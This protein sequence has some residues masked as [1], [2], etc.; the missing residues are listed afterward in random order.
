MNKPVRSIEARKEFS[1]QLLRWWLEN[2]RDFLWR[3]SN[4]AYEVLIAELLLRRTNAEAVRK[5]YVQFLSQFPD[6]TA[7]AHSKAQRIRTLVQPLGLSWRA[8]N[9]VEL[10]KHF[11]IHGSAVPQSIEDLYRLPGVGPYVARAVLINT[12]NWSAVAIDTNVLRVLCRYFGFQYTDNLRR[13][14][15][16]QQFA[17][18][19][20]FGQSVRE[21]NYALLDFAS[22]ICKSSPQCDLCPLSTGCKYFRGGR[23]RDRQ[24]V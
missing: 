9:I 13:N 24:R 22:A 11:R 8:E 19:L 1:E 23:Q 7:F 17:D 15:S 5:V 12:L 16:F 14:K 10:S 21:F 4:D 3:K 6:C 18:S 20:L 2:K